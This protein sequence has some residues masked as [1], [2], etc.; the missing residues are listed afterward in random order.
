MPYDSDEERM[1]SLPSAVPTASSAQNYKR[2]P[3][4]GFTSKQSKKS[5]RLG[6]K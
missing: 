5:S 1:N 6:K 4:G 3:S 2:Q